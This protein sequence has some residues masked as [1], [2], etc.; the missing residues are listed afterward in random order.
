MRKIQDFNANQN[1]DT[2]SHKGLIILT[3]I[4]G[5][6]REEGKDFLLHIPTMDEKRELQVELWIKRSKV[7]LPATF[8]V[9]LFSDRISEHILVSFSSYFVHRFRM[10]KETCPG[11]FRKNCH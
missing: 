1:Q 3:K 5:V 8:W 11:S 9:H 6:D 10:M 2:H 7:N 4:N